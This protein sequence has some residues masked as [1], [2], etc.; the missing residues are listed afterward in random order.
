MP[1][2]DR[3]VG[4]WRLVSFEYL[5][6]DG[7]ATY[8]FGHHPRGFLIY[9]AD[10]HMTM[11]IASEGYPGLP[12]DPHTIIPA[13]DAATAKVLYASYAG[14]YK[15]TATHVI[16]QVEVSLREDWVGNPRVREYAF[17]GNRLILSHRS[18][19]VVWERA[20]AAD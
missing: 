6:P 10:G 1:S 5:I 8:P 4:T 19:T 9:S 20:E 14:R 2:N 15:V 3:F 11:T 16:H 17:V 13:S 18:M 12:G 7:H